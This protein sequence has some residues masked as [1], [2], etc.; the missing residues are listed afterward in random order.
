M[1]QLIGFGAAAF[2]CISGFCF[3]QPD[4][5]EASGT[6][7]REGHGGH[8]GYEKSEKKLLARIAPG[9]FEV[10]HYAAMAQLKKKE[11]EDFRDGS[12]VNKGTGL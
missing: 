8:G 5:R 9:R 11:T 12:G 7:R 6:D 4:G 10:L 3:L 1:G 2:S